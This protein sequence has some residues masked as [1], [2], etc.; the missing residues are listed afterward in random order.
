MQTMELNTLGN[1]IMQPDGNESERTP[2]DA[3]HRR[4]SM[5]FLVRQ[6]STVNT[7][8]TTEGH[9]KLTYWF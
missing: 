5:K 2:L 4:H 7:Q 1:T 8:K 6:A 3:R 9:M